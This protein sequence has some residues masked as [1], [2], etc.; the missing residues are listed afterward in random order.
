M[1]WFVTACAVTALLVL[2]YGQAPD[3]VVASP[4]SAQPNAPAQAYPYAQ[5]GQGCSPT[6]G[7]AAVFTF[8]RVDRGCE[9]KD[10]DEVL[11]VSYWG[12]PT[13]NGPHVVVKD[14]E[15]GQVR[16]Q[17]VARGAGESSFDANITLSKTGPSHIKATLDNGQVI[18]N[19]FVLRE[20]PGQTQSCG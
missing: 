11:V 3:P 14:R 13:V 12:G 2:A 6:D 1:R 8:T 18:D 7:Y 5:R 15:D 16:R 20:C 17:R 19:D 4:A 9:A 10:G